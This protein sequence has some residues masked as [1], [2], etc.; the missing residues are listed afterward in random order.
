MAKERISECNLNRQD[1]LFSRL[2]FK[3][4]TT[5]SAY[6]M[7]EKQYG[8]ILFVFSEIINHKLII[9]TSTKST[10]GIIILIFYGLHL[11]IMNHCLSFSNLLRDYHAKNVYNRNN[12]KTDKITAT[13]E[14]YDI[15]QKVPIIVKERPML[16]MHSKSQ[17]EWILYR[18]LSLILKKHYVTYKK[19]KNP[20]KTIDNAKK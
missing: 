1:S 8:K 16:R 10:V 15:T 14:K 17:T 6:E 7:L 9:I 13:D 4:L 12:K 18:H 3:F 20:L 19:Q 5:K 2:L 11:H